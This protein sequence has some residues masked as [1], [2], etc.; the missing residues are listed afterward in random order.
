M[1]DFMFIVIHIAGC[2]DNGMHHTILIHEYIMHPIPSISEHPVYFCPISVTCVDVTSV[3]TSISLYIFHITTKTIST[4]KKICKMLGKGKK[5][6]C[7]KM[8][9]QS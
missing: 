3:I 9:N 6:K 1:N 8:F 2:S 7:A 4:Y 5:H